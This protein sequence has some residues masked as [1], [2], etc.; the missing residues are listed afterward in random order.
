MI[1][2]GI[3]MT[4]ISFRQTDITAEA[5]VEETV[6]ITSSPIGTDGYCGSRD[7]V[8]C[9]LLEERQASA[10]REQFIA[11]LGHDLRNPLAAIVSGMDL[12]CRRPLDDRQTEFAKL[13]QSSAARMSGLIDDVMDFARGR[14]GD[15]ML[16]ARNSVELGPILIQVIDELRSSRSARHISAELSL[17]EPIDCDPGRLSQLLSNLLANALIHGAT[18]GPVTVRAFC[19]NGLFE[20]SV[21]NGGIQFHPLR[22]PGCSNPSRATRYA[23][24]GRGLG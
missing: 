8:V 5:A 19:R 14:L 13:V 22:F 15:G 16:L 3:Y 7:S 11:V 24:A 21:S 18:T 9:A 1:G 10:L 6:S 4:L 12:I 20:L 2:Q 17:T 23:R